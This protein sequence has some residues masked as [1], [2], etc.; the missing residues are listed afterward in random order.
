VLLE[1]PVVRG[2]GEIGV[3]NMKNYGYVCYALR[4]TEKL[5]QGQIAEMA[6]KADELGG[7]LAKVFVDP[8]SSAPKTAVLSRPAGKEMLETLQ[9][10]DMVPPHE[11][12]GTVTSSLR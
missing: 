9:A 11:A 10:G 2:N 12:Q 7:S 8:G 5:A 3:D 1:K 4:Q 6:R